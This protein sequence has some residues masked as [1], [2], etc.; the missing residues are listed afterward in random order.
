M[1]KDTVKNA[2]V[3]IF[4]EADKLVKAIRIGAK[5]DTSQKSTKQTKPAPEPN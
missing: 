2:K 1:V 3:E 4:S 5:D